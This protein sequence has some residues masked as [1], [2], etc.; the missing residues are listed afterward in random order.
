VTGYRRIVKKINIDI[1]QI[2]KIFNL[3]E[4]IKA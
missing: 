1:R 4:K 3:G 2:L